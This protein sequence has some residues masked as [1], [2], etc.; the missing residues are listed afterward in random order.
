MSSEPVMTARERV[1]ATIEHREPARLAVDLGCHPQLRHLRRSPT[2][3]SCGTWACA[4]SG[5][6][7]TT[8]SSSWPSPR[9]SSS[10]GSGIDAVDIG[11]TFNAADADWH[12]MPLPGGIEVEVPAWFH[13]VQ[14]ADGAWDAFDADGLRIATM[15]LGAS[16]FEDQTHF[17]YLDGHPDDLSRP[18]RGHAH[19]PLVRA[20]AQPL[21]SRRRSRFLGEQLRE[22]RSAAAGADRPSDHDRPAGAICSNGVRSCGAS[23][24]S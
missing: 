12:P 20:G 16:F 18:G 2:P 14:R 24:S 19:R 3:T 22:Q 17:P 6:A 7:S 23:I 10:T 5:R 13:P 9:T 4:T 11:R 21:G 8:W 1:L 15:P